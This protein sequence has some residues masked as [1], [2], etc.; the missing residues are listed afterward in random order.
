M[1][2]G[3][4]LSGAIKGYTQLVERSGSILQIN[5]ELDV[6]FWLL[7]KVIYVVKSLTNFK[8]NVIFDQFLK[9]QAQGDTKAVRILDQLHLR[10]FTPTELLRLLSF[11]ISGKILPNT[12]LWPSSIT[13]KTKYRL[14]GNSVNVKVVTELI[15]FLFIWI[16]VLSNNNLLLHFAWAWSS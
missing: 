8:T 5:E 16:Y 14:I 2:P 9:A 10:Y 6:R 13:T 12:F 3:H 1:N 4:P 11:E 7:P 15:N